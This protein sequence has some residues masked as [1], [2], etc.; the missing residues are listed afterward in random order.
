M[1]AK[2]L[3]AVS[4]YLTLALCVSSF[5]ACVSH[6]GT[7]EDSQSDAPQTTA[8]NNAPCPPARSLFSTKCNSN[9]NKAENSSKNDNSK[10]ERL[11]LMVPASLRSANR[12]LQDN[13]NEVIR[14]HSDEIMQCWT[15]LGNSRTKGTEKVTAEFYIRPNGKVA[16]TQVK[17]DLSDSSTKTLN[18]I[19]KRI[20]TWKFPKRK[21]KDGDLVVSHVFKFS[22][23]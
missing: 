9:E 11:R 18:C 5:A 1:S 4:R 20:L 12:A 21:K 8:S 14:K 2:L 10:G 3:T 6:K 17:S 13:V 16:N 15:S 22:Y 19:D 7:D 23:R